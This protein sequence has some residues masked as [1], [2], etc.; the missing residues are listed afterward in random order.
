MAA[1]GACRGSTFCSNRPPS[2]IRPVTFTRPPLNRKN[3]ADARPANRSGNREGAGSTTPPSSRRSVTSGVPIS[4]PTACSASSRRVPGSTSVLVPPPSAASLR[5]NPPFTAVSMPTVNTRAS[6]S[7]RCKRL[8][9]PDSSPTWPSVSRT[10]TGILPADSPRPRMRSSASPIARSSSV[11]PR[12]AI[13]RPERPQQER[14]GA[15]GGCH[16]HALHRSRAIEHEHHVPRRPEKPLAR[17]RQERQHRELTVH[18][19]LRFHRGARQPPA[20]DEVPVERLALPSQADAGALG[21]RRRAHRVLRAGQL[22]EPAEQLHFDAE[23][24]LGIE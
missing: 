12:E 17:R 7:S 8:R 10:T 9:T 2:A 20:E 6:P 16:L 23:R 3:A 18:E 5:R 13:A 4:R 24:D 14:A 19:E 21:P 1:S 11:P 22:R 15:G